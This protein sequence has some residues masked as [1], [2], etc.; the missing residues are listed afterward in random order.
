MYISIQVCNHR[1]PQCIM[2]F[3]FNNKICWLIASILNDVPQRMKR[4]GTW[5]FN[6][7]SEDISHALFLMKY[8]ATTR[9]VTQNIFNCTGKLPPPKKNKSVMFQGIPN[10][11]L[12]SEI[13]YFLRPTFFWETGIPVNKYQVT[14]CPKRRGK[15]N[16]LAHS[17]T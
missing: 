15:S 2:T 5:F 11:I 9:N 10:I 7:K 17:V 6:Q 1:W 8:K 13:T 3:F 16:R 14:D 4:Y 12:E